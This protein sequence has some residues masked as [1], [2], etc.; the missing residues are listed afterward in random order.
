MIAGGPR[1]EALDQIDSPKLIG[2]PLRQ[3]SSVVATSRRP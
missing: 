1:A 3:A 2:E